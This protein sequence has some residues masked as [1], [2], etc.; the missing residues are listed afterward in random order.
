VVVRAQQEQQQT[1]T[2]TSPGGGW[3]DLGHLGIVN[4]DTGILR[5]EQGVFIRWSKICNAGQQF[6]LQSCSELV[7]PS[8]SLTPAG[9]KA[10]DCINNGL[11]A[12]VLAVNIG[13]SPDVA[14]NI[15]GTLASLTGCGGIVDM[16]SFQLRRYRKCFSSLWGLLD[17]QQH[18]HLHHLLLQH[19]PQ[20]QMKQAQLNNNY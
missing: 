16:K 20:C 14:K 4:R 15:L 18:H 17:Q 12:G 8:G 6:L 5:N 2:T 13:I 1:T 9:D 10:T 11:A 19:H 7:D 3:R